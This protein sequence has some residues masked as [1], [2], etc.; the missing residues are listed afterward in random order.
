MTDVFKQIRFKDLSLGDPFFDSLKQDYPEFSQWFTRKQDDNAL[1]NILQVNG[2]IGAFLYL[3]DHE[4][5]TIQLKEKV[6]PAEPRIKIG[7]LKMDPTIRGKRLGEGAIGI[8]L[9]HW[10]RGDENQIYV[11]VYEK[12][13]TLVELLLKFGFTII[14]LVNATGELFMLKDK[15]D[16]NYATPFSSYPYINPNFKYAGLVVVEEPYH[17]KLFPYSE[18]AHIDY[19]TDILTN[20]AGNGVTKMYVSSAYTGGYEPGEPVLI[21]RKSTTKFPAGFHSAVTSIA[22]ITKHYAVKANNELL[23]NPA[24]VKQILG[25]KSVLTDQELAEFLS[26]KVVDIYELVYEYYFGAGHNVNWKTLHDLDMYN[27]YP[28]NIHYENAAFKDFL[29]RQHGGVAKII[30][31]KAR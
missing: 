28:S 30:G 22:T 14:G 10:L 31:P 17:D 27:S 4:E 15:R 1:A 11:T 2:G 6:L 9:W 16:I 20:V 19:Q 25:N 29:H 26:H 23:M 12:H 24:E 7:T 8:A 18:L 3:K 21:Y 5:E 13:Q